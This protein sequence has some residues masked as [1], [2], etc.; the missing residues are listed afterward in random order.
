MSLGHDNFKSILFPLASYPKP[1]STS[2]ISCAVMIA[3][4]FKAHLSGLAFGLDVHLPAGAYAD[5]FAFGEFIATEYRHSASN[6][7]LATDELSDRARQQGL[8]HA[9]RIEQCVP[10]KIASQTAHSAHTHD[11]CLVAVR[12]NDPGQRELMEALLFESG[13]PLLLFPES[14]AS[15][16]PRSFD[17]ITIAWNDTGPAARAVAC[18]LP[19]L[20]CAKSVRIVSIGDGGSCMSEC[21][22]E[23]AAELGRYLSRHGILASYVDIDRKGD[24]VDEVLIDDVLGNRSDLLVMGGYGHARFKELILGGVTDTVLREPPGFVLMSH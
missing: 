8:S 23:S 19:L 1:T 24:S 17:T 22:E 10:A 2:A 3:D 9:S 4:Q 15:E 20:R 6:A 14:V 13:R 5:V 16:L 7:K 18:A 21:R 12:V 11:L